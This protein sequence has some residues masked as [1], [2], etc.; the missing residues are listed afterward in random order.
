MILV[1]NICPLSRPPLESN[2]RCLFKLETLYSSETAAQA[3]TPYSPQSPKSQFGT[4]CMLT[5]AGMTFDIHTDFIWV[6]IS[7]TTRPGILLGSSCATAGP[8]L[9]HEPLSFNSVRL[10]VDVGAEKRCFEVLAQERTAVSPP[11]TTTEP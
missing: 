9:S 10:T 5:C 3:Y 4:P 7:L 1:C 11:V 8:P 6:A 2:P